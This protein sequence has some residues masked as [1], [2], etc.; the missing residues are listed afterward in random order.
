MRGWA[1][2]EFT[3]TNMNTKHAGSTGLLLH[4]AHTVDTD[5]HLVREKNKWGYDCPSHTYTHPLSNSEY[6]FGTVSH[7]IY[8]SLVIVIPL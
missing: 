4:E 8:C 2:A 6:R 1:T 5:T 7:D 3:D